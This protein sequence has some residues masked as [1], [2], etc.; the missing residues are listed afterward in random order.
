MV[1]QEPNPNSI[2]IIDSDDEPNTT[3]FGPRS[4]MKVDTRNTDDQPKN[5]FAINIEAD[6]GR[7]HTN[8]EHIARPRARKTFSSK[9]LQCSRCK[10][11]T[12]KAKCE[13]CSEECPDTTTLIFHRR[14]HLKDFP[15]HCR[16]CL[17]GFTKISEKAGHETDC[18]IKNR[19]ECY[20]CKRMIQSQND[21][22]GHMRMHTGLR[23]FKCN[24]CNFRFKRASALIAHRGS[25][26]HQNAKKKHMK[27]KTEHRAE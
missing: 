27:K 13:V 11:H 22:T 7:S 4:Q 19:F 23:P 17:R 26:K 14:I 20:L 3:T 10:H 2:V 5:E 24:R 12:K 16:S 6:S 8:P 15:I 1:K 18:S 25:G 9:L 21:L